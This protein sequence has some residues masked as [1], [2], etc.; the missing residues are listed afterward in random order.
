[1]TAIRTLCSK[2]I[3]LKS[4]RSVFCGGIEDAISRYMADGVSESLDPR[5]TF[6]APEQASLSMRDVTV[7]VDGSASASMSMGAGL[8]L[9]VTFRSIV[10][11]S[12]PRLVVLIR[13]Q[14]G[15]RLIHASNRFQMSTPYESGLSDG[16]IRCDLGKLPLV[17]GRYWIT[18]GIGN[19][20]HDTHWV[21][22]AIGFEV[23]ERDIWGL[24]GVP[25]PATS[26]MW[27]P[28]EFVVSPA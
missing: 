17:A 14:G 21:D 6:R 12:D 4:G 24:G 10:P 28:A 25:S 7:L 5:R 11:V 9:D 19:S 15:E 20:I 1:M 16:R 22:D 18:L 13:A 8:S 2:G 3:M 26:M 23:V 27:W